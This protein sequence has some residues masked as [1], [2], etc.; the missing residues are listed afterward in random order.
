MFIWLPCPF[1]SVCILLI[2]L[3][4]FADFY[5]NMK[6]SMEVMLQAVTLMLYLPSLLATWQLC[7]LFIMLY[8]DS[9]S[10]CIMV[11]LWKLFNVYKE[12]LCWIWKKKG[13]D[14]VKYKL[15]LQLYLL[16]IKLTHCIFDSST[17]HVFTKACHWIW[18]WTS[19][20]H[21]PSS[22]PICQNHLYVKVL[23]PSLSTKWP[24]SKWFL[25]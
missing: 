3:N 15:I 2:I 24:F 16:R 18:Y 5:E 7:V 4:Q 6:I 1:I 9:L 23:S 19:S 13:G 21:L 8:H 17:W 12:Y 25:H 11:G 20:I 22:Q 10:C 14:Y